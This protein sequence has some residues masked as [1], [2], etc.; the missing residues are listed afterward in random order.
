VL[1][2]LLGRSRAKDLVTINLSI[3]DLAEHIAVGEADD[4]TVLVRQVLVLVLGDQLEALAIVS[5]TLSA[6]AELDLEGLEVSLV[7]NNLDEWLHKPK[8][9]NT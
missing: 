8:S 9:M 3:D 4:Q 6:P 7:L 2:Q 1:G 5:A